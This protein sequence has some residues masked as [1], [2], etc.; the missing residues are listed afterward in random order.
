MDLFF[1]VFVNSLVIGSLY[2]SIAMSFALT[3]RTARFFNLAHG[4]MGAIGGYTFFWLRESAG[5]DFILSL[6]AGVMAAGVAGFLIDRFIYAPQRGRK[7]SNTVLL[8]VSL[9]VVT[10]IEALLSMIFGTQ[11]RPLVAAGEIRSI[12]VGPA[13]VTQAQIWIVAAN[14]LVFAGLLAFLYKTSFGKMIRAIADDAEVARMLGIRTDFYIGIV[15]F[16][17][18]ALAGLT[19]ILNGLD[20]GLQPMMG[21]YLLLKG[22]IAGIIGCAGSIPGAF[23]GGFLLA[24]TENAG[25]FFI[26]SEWRDAI[27]F[28]LLLIFLA[29]RPQGIL[30]K[31]GG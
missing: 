1:Q 22:I 18:A 15:F 21:F 8:V 13:F 24:A 10:V 29:F 5:A 9:G 11:F 2:G 3:Y 30:G 19:G 28:I 20:T 31:R 27:A 4:S 25:V 6:V 16:I 23:L 17:A 7:A 14:I 12:P 26:G